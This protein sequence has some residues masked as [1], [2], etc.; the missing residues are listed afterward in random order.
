MM[1]ENAIA[2]ILVDVK[3]L[4]DQFRDGGRANLVP[5]FAELRSTTSLVLSD[6]VA[7]YL[8]PSLRQTTYAHIKPKRLTSLLEKLARYG[9]SCRDPVSREKGEKRRKEA[10]AVGRLFPGEN[11]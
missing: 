9:G 6:S 8:V 10:D 11:R 3:F 1:N 4:E 5:L 7:E 2:N